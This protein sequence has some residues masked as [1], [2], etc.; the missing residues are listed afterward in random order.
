M[1]MR[2]PA[3]T[4]GDMKKGNSQMIGIPATETIIKHGLELVNNFVND[5][6]YSMDIDDMLE[7]LLKYSYDAKRKFDIV[8]AMGVCEIADEDM[9]GRMPKNESE[10]KV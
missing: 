2:R 8:A 7:Q 9:L 6:C 5:Y 10:T 4:M 1:F 3:S